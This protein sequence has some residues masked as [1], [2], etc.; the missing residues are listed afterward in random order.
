MRN[1]TA[2]SAYK[3]ATYDSAPPLKIVHM[4]YAGALRFIGQAQSL[5][6]KTE[7][8]EFD[9]ILQKASA[10]IFELRVS[11]DHEVAPELCRDLTALYLFAEDRIRLSLLDRTADPLTAAVSTLETLFEGWKG[12]EVTEQRG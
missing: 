2:A 7:A 12:V 10:V 11:L 3:H 8:K 4:M 1:Q 9:K 5:D 6:P